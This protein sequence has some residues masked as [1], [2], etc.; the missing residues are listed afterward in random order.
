MRGPTVIPE[1]ICTSEGARDALEELAYH[2]RMQSIVNAMIEPQ[3]D[4]FY[5]SLRTADHLQE[6]GRRT[7]KVG[8]YADDAR[9]RYI[10]YVMVNY[11]RDVEL[12]EPLIVARHIDDAR[13]HAEFC[14]A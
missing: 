5:V 1:G 12:R 4:G 6:N 10:G 3:S 7:W 13:R 8:P 11:L 2:C 9:A 14:A